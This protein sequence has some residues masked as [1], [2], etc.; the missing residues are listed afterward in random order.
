[1]CNVFLSKNKKVGEFVC[2]LIEIDIFFEKEYY[3]NTWILYTFK[4]NLL[5]NYSLLCL[6]EDK[7][8]L[9]SDKMQNNQNQSQI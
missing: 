9:S 5:S 7:S 2:I 1:M 8:N 4:F 3:C 6:E